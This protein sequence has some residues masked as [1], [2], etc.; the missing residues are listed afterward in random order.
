M[1]SDTRNFM[2][3]QQLKT[4]PSNESYYKDVIDPTQCPTSL[5]NSVLNDG[6]L[7]FDVYADI[8]EYIWR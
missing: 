3:P 8:F 4:I 7:Y 1:Q 2:Y 6:P 5:I